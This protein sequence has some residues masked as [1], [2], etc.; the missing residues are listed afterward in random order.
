M[1][2]WVEEFSPPLTTSSEALFLA[3]NNGNNRLMSL[4]WCSAEMYESLCK[5]SASTVICKPRTGMLRGGT[6]ESCPGSLR[7]LQALWPLSLSASYSVL[8]WAL[9]LPSSSWSHT[10]SALLSPFS[11][12]PLSEHPS[13]LH[14]STHLL[15]RWNTWDHKRSTFTGSSP[16]QKLQKDEVTMKRDCRDIFLQFTHL[17]S[18]SPSMIWS[19]LSLGRSWS[20]LNAYGTCKDCAWTTLKKHL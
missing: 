1:Y 5:A 4:M 8:L 3:W 19:W 18:P 11:S 20:T 10:I 14:L 12:F 15:V 13:S 17:W 9:V 16:T 2:H 6:L 7:E